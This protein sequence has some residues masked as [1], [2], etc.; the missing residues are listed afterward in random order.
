VRG[1]STPRGVCVRRVLWS[2]SSRSESGT[3]GSRLGSFFVLLVLERTSRVVGVGF[4]V[5]V[6]LECISLFVGVTLDLYTALERSDF[7]I[8]CGIVQA[9]M[10]KFAILG[11]CKSQQHFLLR[12]QY[13]VVIYAIKT[14]CEPRPRGSEQLPPAYSD[15]LES[16]NCE[17]ISTK[18]RT[19]GAEPGGFVHQGI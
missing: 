1:N 3:K 7:V 11:T 13:P 15:V 9:R 8:K 4:V 12:S 5:L 10:D 19:D 17:D 16:Q 14:K 18:L 6:V 2:S